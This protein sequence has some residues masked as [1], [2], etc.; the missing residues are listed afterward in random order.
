MAHLGGASHL[1]PLI[2]WNHWNPQIEFSRPGR[3]ENVLQLT[4]DLYGR[5]DV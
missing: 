2:I 4:L 5:L 1:P 3:P